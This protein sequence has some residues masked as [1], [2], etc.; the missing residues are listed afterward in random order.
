MSFEGTNDFGMDYDMTDA[1]GGDDPVTPGGNDNRAALNSIAGSQTGMIST[2]LQTVSTAAMVL[3]SIV[4]FVNYFKALSDVSGAA[5]ILPVIGVVI[6]LALVIVKTVGMWLFYKN[7]VNNDSKTNGLTMIKVI[8]IIQMV[9]SILAIVLCLILIFIGLSAVGGASNMVGADVSF[10]APMMIPYILVLIIAA[11]T[12]V[13]CY[14]KH[15]KNLNKMSR[16]ISENSNDMELSI[17]PPVYWLLNGLTNLSVAVAGLVGIFSVSAFTSMVK[18]NIGDIGIDFNGG[19]AI[20]A[21]VLLFV[22]GTASIA[23]TISKSV[24]ILRIWNA[25]KIAATPAKTVVQIKE[26]IKE[27]PVAKGP[28]PVPMQKLPI[29]VELIREKT[30]EIIRVN[31][32]IFL[33]GKESGRVDYAIRNNEKISRVHAQIIIRKGKCFIRDN[34]SLNHVKVNGQQIPPST[35]VEIRNGDYVMLADEQ[36]IIQIFGGKF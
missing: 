1:W 19:M 14:V 23:A 10:G 2:V 31:Q 5:K 16:I 35:D 27:V 24:W 6:G 34:K 12:M 28:T 20:L 33:L 17:Y 3:L 30:N 8:N 15:I 7:G 25:L 9:F 29:S 21:C 22:Y 32:E 13:M 4:L 18:E 36:F 11:V 26:V